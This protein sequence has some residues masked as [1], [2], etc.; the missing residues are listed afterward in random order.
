VYSNCGFSSSSL[1]S[2]CIFR[3]TISTEGSSG[4]VGAR[5][6]VEGLLL[7]LHLAF[8]E[9]NA[10]QIKDLSVSKSS[11]IGGGGSIG[12]AGTYCELLLG[13]FGEVNRCMR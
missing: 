10:K 7:L 13:I 8:L 5:S 9:G 4:C 6:G 11:A 1:T 2:F 3:L 12:G